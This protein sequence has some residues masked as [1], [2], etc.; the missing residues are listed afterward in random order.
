MA[1]ESDLNSWVAPDYL[2]RV[3]EYS[4]GLDLLND[5]VEQDRFTSLTSLKQCRHAM[6]HYVYILENDSS[7]LAPR[8]VR[9]FME[10]ID[11]IWQ[12]ALQ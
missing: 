3:Q 2:R 8:K 12:A 7:P 11:E 10:E 4:A 1:Y 6:Q 5:L 9:K